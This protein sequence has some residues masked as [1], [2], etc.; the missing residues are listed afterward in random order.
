[1]GIVL[2]RVDERLIHGQVI[3]GW[4][5]HLRPDRYVVVDDELAGSEWEKELYRL[6]LD[7]DSEVAFLT[8]EEAR[9]AV[10][11]LRSEKARIV[12]LTR[13]VDHMARL[14][15]GGLLAGAEVN[16]GG[17]HYRPGRTEV[18]PYLHLDAEDREAVRTLTEEGVTVTGRDLPETSRV[19]VEAFLP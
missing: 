15:R 16:L 1:M 19:P 13:D 14:S 3:L 12:L 7:G 11:G 18:R 17:L 10:G 5:R 2:F 4:G 8:V 6:T 9:D